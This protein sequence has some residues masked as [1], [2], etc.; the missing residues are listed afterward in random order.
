MENK[1]KDWRDKKKTRKEKSQTPKKDPR[2]HERFETAID[3]HG[4]YYKVGTPHALSMKRIDTYFSKYSEI[5][6]SLVPKDLLERLL[7]IARA[8]TIL[9]SDIVRYN[10]QLDLDA[11]DLATHEL[12]KVIT[13]EEKEYITTLLH[14]NMGHY[15]DLVVAY[16]ETEEDKLAAKYLQD[17]RR[18]REER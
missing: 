8:H 17:R 3:P 7:R 1:K 16:P 18:K 14:P 2:A 9:A 6:F 4:Y 5:Q 11:I 12:G 10:G 15:E 13:L